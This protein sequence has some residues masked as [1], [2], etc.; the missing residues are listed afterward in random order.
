MV[1]GGLRYDS[2]E[3]IDFMIMF[4]DVELDA[5]FDHEEVRVRN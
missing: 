5:N 4:S 3:V 2:C 1:I